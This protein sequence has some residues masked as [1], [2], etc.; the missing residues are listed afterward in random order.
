MILLYIL[1]TG[2]G[3]DG[4]MF[5]GMDSVGPGL[6]PVRSD[7]SPVALYFIMWMFV[8]SFFAMNLFVGVIV[9]SFNRISKESD[10]SATMTPEQQQWVE[11]IR[12]MSAQKPISKLRPPR[13]PWRLAVHSLINLPAFDALMAAVIL[14]NVIV[15]GCDFWAIEQ[16]DALRWYNLANTTFS[17]IYYVEC[18][19]KL[20]ALGWSY[21]RDNW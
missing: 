21:F 16:T 17:Y 4:V 20:T 7:S 11:S 14:S 12:A 8:G 19:L 5:A 6:A 1:S 9:E 3:W 15:M 18:V 2:D 10:V 13:A